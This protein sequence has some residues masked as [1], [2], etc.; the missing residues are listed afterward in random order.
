MYFYLGEWI[1]IF[2]NKPHVFVNTAN[3]IN[4]KT[5]ITRKSPL[6]FLTQRSSNSFFVS[7]VTPI[8]IQNVIKSFKSGK[9]VGP[10]GIPISLLKLLCDYISLPLCEIST[11][12]SLVDYFQI[13]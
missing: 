8:E 3:K 10:F 7:P 13:H 2:R 9:A 11:N 5:S 4:E 12:L 1:L 6:D